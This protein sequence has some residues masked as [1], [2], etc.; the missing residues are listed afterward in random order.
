MSE[1]R[2]WA[3]A[4]RWESMKIAATYMAINKDGKYVLH[5]DYAALEAECERWERSYREVHE[6]AL[7]EAHAYIQDLRDELAGI[8]GQKEVGYFVQPYADQPEVIERVDDS[9][10]DD[11][12][13]FPLYR[14]PPAAPAQPAAQSEFG[15]ALSAQQSAHV[16]VPRELV[17][18]AARHLNDWLEL[19]QCE[20]EGLHYC[21]RTQV[22][23][24]NRQ[25]RALLNGGE[26]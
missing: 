15:A 19:D 8:K 2:R 6:P 23:A 14:L 10:A 17:Q 13:V 11:E 26:A 3:H 18:R 21:G 22:A 7:Q 20:C 5:D 16:S 1:V 4:V 24:T 9:C 12:D 25:L